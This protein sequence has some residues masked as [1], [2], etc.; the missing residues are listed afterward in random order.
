MKKLLL[1]IALGAVAVAALPAAADAAVRWPASCTTMACVNAHLNNLDQRARAHAAG[2]TLTVN[3]LK[4]RI[5]SLETSRTNQAAKLACIGERDLFRQYSYD[6]YGNFLPYLD[7][8]P[9]Y[10]QGTQS[11]P[12]AMLTDTCGG[13]F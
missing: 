2:Q 7:I 4:A 8:S 9:N 1:M 13:T 6:Y 12:Y 3:A 5:D 11:G 10:G